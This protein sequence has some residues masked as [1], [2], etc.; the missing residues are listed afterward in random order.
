MHL[1]ISLLQKKNRHR[2]KRKPLRP[3]FLNYKP[4]LKSDNDNQSLQK[5]TTAVK[6]RGY[7]SKDKDK[8]FKDIKE[9][10]QSDVHFDQIEANLMME[11]R[12]L[13]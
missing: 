3:L 2:S 5:T 11:L 7:D 10:F 9:L 6:A 1:Q 12:K 8:L 13:I 4:S